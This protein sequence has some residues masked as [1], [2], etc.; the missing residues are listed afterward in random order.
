MFIACL[1]IASGCIKDYWVKSD[2]HPVYNS[3][4]KPVEWF[5]SPLN[6]LNQNP[7]A[8]Q[9]IPTIDLL[10][11]GIPP[12]LIPETK[13]QTMPPVHKEEDKLAIEKEKA[14]S[15]CATNRYWIEHF[16]DLLKKE[17]AKPN[18]DLKTIVGIEQAIA[19]Y[20]GNSEKYAGLLVKYPELEKQIE[21]LRTRWKQK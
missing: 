16:Q 18:P 19:L 9:P 15:E 5:L 13:P 11:Q 20:R 3:R 6:R 1:L 2:T 21:D 7:Q 4:I 12:V 8:I 10:A 14:V 17:N